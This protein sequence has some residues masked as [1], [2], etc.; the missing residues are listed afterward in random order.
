[1]FYANLPYPEFDITGGYSIGDIVFWKNH[2]YTALKATDLYDHEA[3]L[4]YNYVNDVPY[5][6]VFPDDKTNGSKYWHDEGAFFVPAGNLL[7]QAAAPTLIT[8]QS[9]LDL[10]IKADTTPGFNAGDTGYT[11]ASLKGWQYSLERPPLGTMEKDADYETTLNGVADNTTAANGWKLL[12]AGD[13]VGAGERF[14]MHFLPIVYES[15]PTTAP[16]G[17]TSQ[18]IIMTYFTKGDSR[19][20]QMVMYMIDLTIYHLY[21]RVAPKNIP[22]TRVDRY[23]AVIYWLKNVAKGQDITADIEKIQPPQG[24]RIRWGSK[25]KRTNDY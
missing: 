19:N 12:K 13:Q 16:S 24:K 17:Q 21:A 25:I 22:Q 20:Q 23:D 14:I 10:E 2:T 18:Q 5:G 1:M 7:T 3:E 8:T 6:N 4:Q 9:R 11:D 15:A